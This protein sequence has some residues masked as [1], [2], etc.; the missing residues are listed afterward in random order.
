MSPSVVWPLVIWLL[1]LS[2]L[3]LV[4]RD[5]HIELKRRVEALEALKE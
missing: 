5:A 1:L 4:G 3:Q 2:F